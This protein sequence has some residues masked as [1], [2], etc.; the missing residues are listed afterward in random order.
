M[1]KNLLFVPLAFAFFTGGCATTPCGSVCSS[2]SNSAT[3]ESRFALF[4]TNKDGFISKEELGAGNAIDAFNHYDTNNDK[5]VSLTE[6]KALGGKADGFK[7]LDLNHD[8]K[9][10]LDEAKSNPKV[11][12][13]LSGTF[14]VIDA[15]KDGKITKKEAKAY[16]ATRQLFTP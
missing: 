6:W 9:I 8:G 12:E 11:V 7:R 5:V 3:L 4:D 15:N 1:K 2:V 14:A 10:T 13:T 16:R